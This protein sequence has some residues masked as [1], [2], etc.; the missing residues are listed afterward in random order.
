MAIVVVIYWASLSCIHIPH[1]V[2]FLCTFPSILEDLQVFYYAECEIGSMQGLTSVAVRA[3]Y[4]SYHYVHSSWLLGMESLLQ[5]ASRQSREEYI[6]E[7]QR[8]C[9]FLGSDYVAVRYVRH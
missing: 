5:L 6:V 3:I 4:S 2:I 1:P 9:A 7:R 8:R